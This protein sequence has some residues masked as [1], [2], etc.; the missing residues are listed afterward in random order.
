MTSAATGSHANGHSMGMTIRDASLDA[1]V[2]LIVSGA[3]AC[4]G[5]VNIGS[6]ATAAAGGST[7]VASTTDAVNSSVTGPPVGYPGTCGGLMCAPDQDCCLTTSTCFDPLTETCP[8]LPTTGAPE[9]TTPCSA[10][11]D[12]A[13][14]E[15]CTGI[16]PWI[17]GGPGYCLGRDQ[18]GTCSGSPCVSCGCNGVTYPNRQTACMQGVRTPL[19][20]NGGHGC[21]EPV[22]DVFQAVVTFCG[23]DSMCPAGQSC[24]FITGRCY[25]ASVPALCSYPPE[26]TTVPCVDGGPCVLDQQYCQGIGCDA[27]G[28]CVNKASPETCTGQVAQICGCD[29]ATYL[30]QGCAE[31]AGVRV[32]SQGPCP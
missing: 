23:D 11:T 13:P 10:N 18:C 3:A 7:A 9:G 2:F 25:D 30:N 12:C 17:C 16:N 8:D 20:P 21:G 5:D 4:D 15:F 29:G 22:G 24:C 14:S 31:V 6:D 28:G 26:P 27:P 32:A 1:L 19:I